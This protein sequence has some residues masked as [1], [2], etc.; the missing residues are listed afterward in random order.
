MAN[1][2]VSDG[3]NVRVKLTDVSVS[4]LPYL[5]GLLPYIASETAS[6]GETITGHTTGMWRLPCASA[7]TFGDGATV[8]W[9]P[10]TEL[11][12]STAVSGCFRLGVA[13]VQVVSGETEVIV[14]LYNT[15][16]VI[17]A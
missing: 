14:R 6:A 5:K 2:F 10:A 7:V 15:S 9:N 13:E 8:H 3:N 4:G 11:A 17:K 12:V 1:N 16:T